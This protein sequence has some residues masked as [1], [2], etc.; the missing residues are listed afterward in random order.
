M[1]LIS[2]K[3]HGIIDYALILFLFLSPTLFAMPKDVTTYTY[4]LATLQ[5][6]LTV[7]T[8][9][10]FGLF[11][12]VGLK[13]HQLIELLISIGMITAAY[14]LFNYDERTKPYYACVGIFW[15]IVVI[16]TDY[17]KKR[18]VVKAPIL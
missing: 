10:S 2:P 17:S 13:A 3:L 11:R 14:T 18:D 7:L 6:I 16:F 15:L 5:L 9:Y 4:T 8:D 12:M 1:K